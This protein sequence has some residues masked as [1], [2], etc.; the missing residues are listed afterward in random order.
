MKT[1][2]FILLLCCPFVFSCAGPTAEMSDQ[3]VFTIKKTVDF[4]ISGDGIADNWNQTEWVDIE[5]RRGK[6]TPLSTKAKILYSETGMYFLIY[7]EDIRLTATMEADNLFLWKEDIVE[8]FLAPDP[9][10]WDHFEYE[11]SPLN[12][13]LA[14]FV[15]RD[16]NLSFVRWLPY[17]Y[18]ETD[19]EKT[20]HATSVIGGEKKSMAAVDGWTAEFFIPYRLLNIFEN[21]PPRSGMKWRGNLYRVDYDHKPSSDWTWKP[22]SGTYHNTDEYGTFLFE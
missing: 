3:D 13:E 1:L 5:Q 14:L 17:Y 10:C 4:E 7:C 12:Y 6:N 11:L 9:G 16:E 22:V 19:R 15:T 8:I 20:I 2:K 21:V 18:E